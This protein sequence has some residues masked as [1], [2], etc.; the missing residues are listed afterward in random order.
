MSSVCHVKRRWRQEKEAL[1]V[2]HVRGCD[3][4]KNAY[5]RGWALQAPRSLYMLLYT[6]CHALAHVFT[7][8]ALPLDLGIDVSMAFRRALEAATARSLQLFPLSRPRTSDPQAMAAKYDLPFSSHDLHGISATQVRLGLDLSCP[9]GEVYE[10]H[11][12]RRLLKNYIQNE[13]YESYN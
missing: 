5:V 1:C 4:E 6:F 2:G 11:R 10:R 9:Y 7:A 3:S 12:Y 8:T 13:I